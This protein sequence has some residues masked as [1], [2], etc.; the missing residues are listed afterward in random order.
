MRKF[1]SDRIA[2]MS[3]E[4]LHSHAS[5]IKNLLSYKNKRD[6]KE[7]LEIEFCYL[8]REIF[9]REKRRKSHEKFLKDNGRNFRRF[10]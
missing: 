9:I 1:N 8:Q 3:D 5:K 7:N 10:N 6:S 4:E 2:V